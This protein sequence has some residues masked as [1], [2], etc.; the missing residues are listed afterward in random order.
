[1]AP[2]EMLDLRSF[3]T[4]MDFQSFKIIRSGSYLDYNNIMLH[5]GS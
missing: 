1:M 4:N 2:V 3:S 5:Q